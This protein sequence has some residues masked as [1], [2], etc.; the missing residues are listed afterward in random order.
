MKQKEKPKYSMARC[1]Q[2]MVSMAWKH[3]KSVLVLCAAQALLQVGQNLTQLFVAPVIL[4]KVE[5]T[6]PMEELLSSILIF[7]AALYVL[8]FILNYWDNTCLIGRVHV[9]TSIVKEI[10]RKS[11]TT[12]FPNTGDPKMLKLQTGAHQATG[13]NDRGTEKIWKTLTSLLVNLGSFAVYLLLLTNMNGFLMLV[14]TLTSVAGFL[15]NRSVSQWEYLHKDENRQFWKQTDYIEKTTRSIE[16]AKDIR[17]FGLGQWLSEIYDGVLRLKKAWVLRREKKYILAGTVDVLLAVL[18]NG[19]AYGYLIQKVLNEGLSASEFL[20]Y[21]T[22]VS[23]FTGW[24]TGIL[25]ECTTLRQEC[26]EI[27]TV[28]EYLDYPEPFRF[29][30]G[31][32][33]PD[34]TAC[35]LKLEDVTF[36][37]PGAEQPLFEHF[38][39]TIRPGEKVAV[40]GL[41]GAGKT[42]LVKLLCGFYD[43]EE[44][45]VLLNGVD[46]REYNRQD[47]YNL[48]SAVYQ[49]YSVLDVTVEENVAQTMEDIDVQRVMDCLEKA[50]LKDF[51]SQLPQGLQTH[52][53]RDVYLDGVLFS[54][55]QTQRLM[56]AR[57]L[58]KDGPI[59][60][61]DEP[62]A[63][64][65]PIAESDIYQKYN[66]MTAGKTSLFI[67]HRLASTRFCD[68][69][70]YLEAGKIR[71]E[72]THEQLLGLGGAYAKL[73]EIQSRYYQEGRD[74]RGEE[75]F[76]E[77]GSGAVSALREG[78]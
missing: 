69:I 9:R 25:G 16:T 30:G 63:A 47:Y 33:L 65:D 23:G 39:L 52:V 5:Q 32:P 29:S 20:L 73:F 55:G 26:Q 54:G 64:L 76:Y 60:V 22:A 46:I 43:P 56:L 17:I 21:F 13:A 42:T 70:L 59:L 14:V 3:Q 75:V 37:Y 27:A 10:I 48:L 11:I 4:S 44:G 1:I 61:L 41:N 50:G 57:A 51:I 66:E 45:R 36:R 40:V 78:C 74:F 28:L 62:T 19:I 71:E 31:K 72:G 24:V 34:I 77:A 49:D 2:Y 8:C 68:R 12:A 58:Y 15:V 67:S 7:S 38:N 18:R 53:G 35:E 6:A